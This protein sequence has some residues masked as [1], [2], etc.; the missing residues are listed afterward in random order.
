M[1]GEIKPEL[2]AHFQIAQFEKPNESQ[3]LPAKYG[4]F[5]SPKNQVLTK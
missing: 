3:M 1:F 5:T 2:M 4:I